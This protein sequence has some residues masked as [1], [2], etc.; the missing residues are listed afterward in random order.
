MPESRKV[1]VVTGSRAEYGLL[2][3]TMRCIAGD[4]RLKLQVIATGS[5]LAPEFGS[6]WRE[7]ESDGIAIDWKL[8]AL[9]ASDSAVGATKSLGLAVLGFAE[10]YAQMRPDIVLVLGDRYEILAAASAALLNRIPV[11]HIHGGEVTEA[12]F[13]DSIRHAITKMAQWHFVA[14]EPYRARVIQMGEAPDRVFTVG[15]PGLDGMRTT[16]WLSRAELESDL[17]IPLSEPLFLIT[18]HPATLAA[19]DPLVPLAEL[20]AALDAFPDASCVFTFANADPGG[21]SI[22]DAIRTYAAQRRSPA[23]AVASLGSRRYLSLMREANVIV[24]NSSSGVIEAP[25]LRRPTVN[26]GDRQSGRLKAASVIDVP[27]ARGAIRA[28]IER[29]QS[30]GFVQQTRETVSLYGD[31][32]ASERITAKLHEVPL[33]CDKPFYDIRHEN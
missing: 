4:A 8:D 7:I 15:A 19:E 9:V 16:A 25:A 10:A 27:E 31:G 18:Y 21:R 12:A 13:D 14:A 17:G 24:G 1:C 32:R 33:R 28:A 23:V 5:H 26:I 2:R 29:A 30:P 3:E 6:T 11:G 20:F 22:N